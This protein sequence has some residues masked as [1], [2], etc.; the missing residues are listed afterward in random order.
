MLPK[1]TADLQ[2]LLDYRCH[3][4]QGREAMGRDYP[5]DIAACMRRIA[6]MTPQQASAG[7]EGSVELEEH[8]GRGSSWI[9]FISL[10]AAIR[11]R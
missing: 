4:P 6:D 1:G 10:R 9:L 11:R 7:G 5:P 3:L 8:A 2:L